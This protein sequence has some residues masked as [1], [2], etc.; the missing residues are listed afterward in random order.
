[1]LNIEA[2]AEGLMKLTMQ[3]NGLLQVPVPHPPPLT[4]FVPLPHW[5]ITGESFGAECEEGCVFVLT[6]AHA[7][8]A[9]SG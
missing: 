1:M 8:R 9:Y 4:R 2:V 6:G 7:W 5:L 3:V